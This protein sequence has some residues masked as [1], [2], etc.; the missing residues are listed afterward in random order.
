[1]PKYN[2]FDFEV[3]YEEEPNGFF[4]SLRDSFEFCT[5]CD[6]EGPLTLKKRGYVCPEC[7]TLVLPNG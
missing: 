2:E 6:Y 4:D 1:M 3:P 7:Q 5:E